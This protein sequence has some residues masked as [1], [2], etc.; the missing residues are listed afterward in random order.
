M[1]VKRY[2]GK[3][4]PYKYFPYLG[5]IY[6]MLLL[7]LIISGS[8]VEYEFISPLVEETSELQNFKMSVYKSKPLSQDDLIAKM[9]TKYNV[10]RYTLHCVLFH[11]SNYN[12][13]AVG[14]SGKAVGAAQIWPETFIRIRK[15]C[16][17]GEGER[18]DFYDSLETLACGLSKGRGSEWSPVKLGK[19]L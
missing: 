16:D 4:M 17:L 11:E 10:H 2:K 1:K 13:N 6:L 7:G 18:T 9:A 3:F 15:M 14:D 8:R 12:E 19:C 5:I